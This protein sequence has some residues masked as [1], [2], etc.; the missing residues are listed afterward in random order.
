MNKIVFSLL[1]LLM[2]TPLVAQ[3]FAFGLRGGPSYTTLGGEGAYIDPKFRFGY[4]LG[5][6]VSVVISESLYF[7]SGLHFANK[8]ARPKDTF[9]SG[10]YPTVRRFGFLDLPLLLKFRSGNSF[11]LLAGAQPSLMI[12]SSLASGK[13]K[14]KF[15]DRGRQISALWKAYD[16]AAVI[17]LGVDLGAAMHLQTTYEHGFID[18]SEVLNS[19]FN[20][21]FKLTIGKTF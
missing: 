16:L 18:I 10:L 2:T 12:S 11:Y 19:A 8:G 1:V 15:I 7:E 21:G 4:H 17:G 5:G 9:P 20:R 3:D 14:N 6:Y 13:G